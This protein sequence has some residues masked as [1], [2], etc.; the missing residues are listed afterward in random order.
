MNF[1][2]QIKSLVLT[3]L[4]LGF[5][6]PILA[7]SSQSEVSYSGP[8]LSG[9]EI[10]KI[11]PNTEICL[12][13]FVIPSNLNELYLVAQEVSNHQMKPLNNSQLVSEFGQSQKVNKIISFLENNGYEIVYESPFSVFAIAPASIVEKTFS[14]NLDLYKDNNEIYYKPSSLP[15]IPQLM[16]NVIIGGLTNYTLIQPQYFVLGK[17]E[18][19]VIEP[20][21]APRSLPLSYLQF[22]ALYYTPQDIQ[23]AYNVSGSNPGKNVTIAVVDAYGDPEIYQDIHTFD[24]MFHLPPVNLSV[25]PVGPYHPIFG[26]FTGWNIET[27]LDVEAAHSMSPYAKIDLVVA[28]NNGAA[29]FEAIDLIVSED[30]AQVVSMS[31]GFPEN[32]ASASGFY[33]WYQGVPFPNYPYLDYYFALGTAEGISFFAA[34]G[35]DG[36][37]QGTLTTY[38]GVL[39]P[40]SSP[41]VTAVG[42]TSLYVNVTSGYLTSLN[43]TATYGY[44]TAWSVEPQYES[45]GTSTV[46]SGGG[47]STLFPSPWYQR[48]ITHSN[49]RTT[50]D[51]AADANPYT[52]FVTIVDGAECIIGGTSLA[53]P[54]WAGTA[55]D[56]DSYIGHS[57]GLVNPLLYGIYQ[58]STL[59]DEAFH[60][61]SFGYNGKYFANYTYNLVTGLGSPN[62]GMLEYVIKNYMINQGLKISVTTCE[63][64]ITQPW[65]MYG[66]AFKILAYISTPN[67]TT[68]TTGDFNAYIYTLN[69]YLASVPLSFNGT[70]WV[71]SYTIQKGEPQNVWSIVVNGSIYGLTGIGQT[72]ID[73]G[74]S[75]NIIFP[76]GQ[77]LPV[78][79]SFPVVVC[80]YY[81][82]GTPVSNTT[83]VAH[84][85]KD[86][87]TIFNV[88]LLPTSTPGQ[89]EGIGTLLS[90]MPEGTYIMVINNTYGSAYTYNY[91]G[92]IIYGLLFTPINDGMPSANVGQNITLLAFTY[93]QAGLGLFTSNVTAFV[94][95]PQNQLVA[96]IPMS[97]A[98]DITEFGIYNL[99]GYHEANFTIPSNFTPGFYTVIIHST[100]STSVGI[101]NSNFTTAFYV[102]PSE[103]SYQVRSVSTVYEGQNLKIYANITYSN[104]TEVK[105]G[106]FSATLFPSQLNFESLILEFETETLLQYNSTLG[107]WVGIAKIPSILTDQGTIYQ[108]GNLYEL[109]GAWDVVITGTSPFG[110]NLI[111]KSYTQ[112]MPYTY[113]HTLI[114]TPEN[115]SEIPLLTYNGTTYEL[116]DIYS[117][118]ITVEGLHNVILLN[119][120]VGQI[121]SYNSTLIA[122]DSRIIQINSESSLVS[123][124]K[125]TIGGRE[126]AINSIN[127]NISLVSSVIEDSTYAFNQSDSIITQEGVSITNVTS[128]STLPEP[129][130]V[131]ISPT[132]VTTSST[133]ITITIT[134][135]NLKV[136]GVEMDGSS[137]SYSVSSTSSGIK[138]TI[139][140]DASLLPSGFYIFTINVNDGLQY[141]LQS[142]VYNSYHEVVS[143]GQIQSAEH[144]IT[145][146]SHSISSLS[147]SITVAY[148][149]GIIGIII[150]LIALFF[151]LR[152]RG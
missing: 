139:P 22:S 147:S 9:Y 21:N 66:S 36:A 99:F 11:N 81:P 119:S 142:G 110:S 30:L 98:P 94:Y 130:I 132:N 62:V 16:K 97:L 39:F 23:G 28:A 25:I 124:I 138:I 115:V 27:A 84:F 131:S 151:S 59:Y 35:D 7:Y 3:I 42:G 121:D 104:G 67:G 5:L 47:Y 71:G 43:S 145:T 70:Y 60:P 106:E 107:E 134:G 118:S 57:L 100:I 52:G 109:S 41:F 77:I 55:A 129:K 20:S 112:V 146:L 137:I 113:L 12:E 82:N 116:D 91:F 54:L 96:T 32:L 80:A 73:V 127:S 24:K 103:L 143:E 111:A 17:L 140:F 86:G 125:D 136:T 64:Q 8:S 89:Y 144:S 49:F 29:L 18:H 75:I 117:P 152:K 101:E 90:P 120:I 15:Q 76:V 33:A 51:V 74:E 14:V 102:E 135:E 83:F 150:A 72:D 2:Q 38:G 114:I 122:I 56:I 10:G 95:N 88:S 126:F 92:G 1:M 19:G 65:Y 40:S 79:Q 87:K 13:F 46:S 78:D 149:L 105:Y 123:L 48:D 44:E 53:T 37:Y 45:E 108:G 34:S 4:I 26:L 133:N 68:V 128:L 58:N 69:G 63:P 61:V 93:D 31:W 50:P 148:A 141:S 85:I 6:F